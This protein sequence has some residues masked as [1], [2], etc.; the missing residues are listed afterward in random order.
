MFSLIVP[1]RTDHGPREEIW[2]WN[3]ERWQE[4]YDCEI[5]ECDS[6]DEIFS[7]GKSRNQGVEQAKYSDLVIADSDT[8][9]DEEAL[10]ELLC[11]GL[12]QQSWYIPYDEGRYY[13]LNE[14][15]TKEL[16]KMNPGSVLREPVKGEWEFKITSWAGV[17]VLPRHAF[18]GYDPRFVGWGWED[19]A[20]QLRMDQT[21]K[22]FERRSGYVMHMWHPRDGADFGDKCELKNRQLFNREYRR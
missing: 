7:R 15:A 14:D 16:L 17:L 20:F 3:K 18:C 10:T 9:A 4:L 12:T 11:S 5:V 19:N 2:N 22:P 21:F 6:G 13:N 8:V 1:W